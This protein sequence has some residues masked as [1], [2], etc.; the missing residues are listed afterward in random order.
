[1]HDG[2]GQY[3]LRPKLIGDPY[4]FFT[5]LLLVAFS[6]VMLYSTTGVISLEKY[7]DPFFFVKRQAF[8]AVVG[9]IALALISRININYLKRFSS[10]LYP[11]ALIL[12]LVPIVTN[13][14][15]D[16]GGATRWVKLGFFRFQP[17]ELAKLL[18]VIYFASYLSRHQGEL[19]AFYGGVLKPFILLIVIGTLFL[20]QPDFGSTAVIV[21][22][23]LSMTLAAGVRLRYLTVAVLAASLLLTIMVIVSPYRMSR[24]VNFLQP[25]NDSSG[26]GYQLVQSLIAVGSGKLSGVGVGESQQKL[27]FL[28]AA[29]TD[30]IFAVIAEELGFIGAI[31]IVAL[32][33]FIFWR[34]VLLTQRFIDQPFLF[35]LSLGLTLLIVVPALLNIGVVLGLLPTK[36]MVLPFVGYGGSNLITSLI[37]VGIMLAVSRSKVS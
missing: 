21:V 4:L 12:L 32:I 20:L 27:F 17:G 15:D 22:V 6:L 14:G 7:G 33:L 29:H 19:S 13:L 10:Y 5:V 26:K 18:F 24:V 35:S 36:G 31:S 1:M 9:L 16:A 11:T 8:S 28:P 3:D 23:A 34:G 2:L 30:F 25:W 37:A